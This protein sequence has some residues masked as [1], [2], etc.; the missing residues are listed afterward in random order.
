[1]VYNIPGSLAL[2]VSET[3]VEYI[4]IRGI[5]SR[6]FGCDSV[7]ISKP[8]LVRFVSTETMLNCPATL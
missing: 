5:Q 7:T 3:T 1:M 6:H 8:F 2:G 4:Y